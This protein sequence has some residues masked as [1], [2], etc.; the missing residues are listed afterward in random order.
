MTGTRSANLSGSIV[1]TLKE[2][3]ITWQYPPEHRHLVGF[4][5]GNA[6]ELA[7]KLNELLALPAETRAGLGLAARRAV[8]RNWSW[9]AI[10]E[11]LLEPFAR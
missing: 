6:E 2:R 4:E 1:A 8:E 3:I 10:G 11:R 9:T 5:A 7:A